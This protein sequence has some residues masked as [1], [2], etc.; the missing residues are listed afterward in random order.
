M[1]KLL[2]LKNFRSHKEREIEFD[3]GINAVIGPNGVGKT[4]VLEA[5]HAL[6]TGSS[7]RG[8][9]QE[10][11]RHGQNW[12]RVDAVRGNKNTYSLI[13]DNQGARFSKRRE[14]NGNPKSFGFRDLPVVLFE[15]EQLR[16]FHGQPELRRE[17]LDNLIARLNDNYAG[18]LKRYTRVLRQRNAALK[19]DK[20]DR[21]LLF[22]LGFKLGEYG[23][24]LDKQRRHYLG[25]LNKRLGT[26][27]SGLASSKSEVVLRFS[28][29]TEEPEGYASRL[30][31]E[32][33]N[34]L[35]RDRLLGYTSV[36]PHR[37][38]FAATLDGKAVSGTASRGETRTLA[39]ACKMVEVE[40]IE[41]QLSTV[42]TLLLDDVLSE[43]DEKRQR[44]L[45]EGIVGVQTIICATNAE[46][47]LGKTTK[48]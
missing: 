48:L 32:L 12:T 26:I 18:A 47:G 23:A 30:I 27:Y 3:P 16:M 36:G 10:M 11:I 33:E 31:K 25:L 17:W 14:I 39:V 21:D 42:P 29:R 44:R 6:S 22:V 2:R 9:D 7:F 45:L 28:R 41:Q 5:V 20:L 8:R 24:Q 13:L 4:N 46:K 34:R 15:P 40:L 19:H 43:L 35:E 37:D 1:I 38:D